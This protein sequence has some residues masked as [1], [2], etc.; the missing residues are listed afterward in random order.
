MRLPTLSRMAESFCSLSRKSRVLSATWRRNSSATEKRRQEQAHNAA[1]PPPECRGNSRA[2]AAASGGEYGNRQN[3]NWPTM[4]S[5]ADRL[6]PAPLD[7]ALNPLHKTAERA[8][9]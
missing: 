1:K 6:R 2:P 7:D 9:T 4:L 8:D 5:D 3:P